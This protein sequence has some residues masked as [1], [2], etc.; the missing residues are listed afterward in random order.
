MPNAVRY[1][2]TRLKCHNIFQTIEIHH[3]PKL[4]LKTEFK[5]HGDYNFAHV[6]SSGDNNVS[7]VNSTCAKYLTNY[8]FDIVVFD[9]LRFFIQT[10]PV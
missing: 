6:E 9:L 7:R 1:F 5:R 8:S 3:T 2:E 4:S 10:V